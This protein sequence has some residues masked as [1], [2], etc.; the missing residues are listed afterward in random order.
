MDFKWNGGGEWNG[1]PW[2]ADLPTDSAL[3]LYIFAAFLVAPMW[4]FTEEDPGRIEGPSGVLYL[5]KVPPKVN[6]E[7]MAIISTWPPLGSKVS[8]YHDV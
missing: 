5:G 2:S 1:K 8:R 3:L 7:Y 6:G 4:T